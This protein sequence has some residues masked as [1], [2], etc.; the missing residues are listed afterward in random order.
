MLALLFVSSLGSALHARASSIRNV[1]L[2]GVLHGVSKR[3]AGLN[4]PGSVAG[5]T[6]T[7]PDAPADKIVSGEEKS[8]DAALGNE[9][10]AELTEVS[11]DL[12]TEAEDG[13][14][15]RVSGDALGSA[16]SGKSVA[17]EDGGGD[18]VSVSFIA[19]WGFCGANKCTFLLVLVQKGGYGSLCL[20]LS[21]GVCAFSHLRLIVPR[22]APTASVEDQKQVSMAF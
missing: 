13:R 2:S 19:W 12:P 1:K 14:A 11:I 10:S 15:R 6:A 9:S 21:R 16:A 17:W 4:T 5:S 8:A 18:A 3:G 20:L 7:A 22:S